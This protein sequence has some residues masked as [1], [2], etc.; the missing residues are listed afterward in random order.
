MAGLCAFVFPGLGHLVL[1]KPLQAMLWFALIAVGY[2]L[3]IVPGLCLHLISVVDAAR[4]ER[5]HTAAIIADG[6]RR[7]QK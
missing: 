3:F 1:G 4:A 6:V 7:G 5:R 2:V